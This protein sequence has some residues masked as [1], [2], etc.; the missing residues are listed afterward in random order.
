MSRSR[1]KFSESFK[2][3]AVDLVVSSGQ[4]VAKVARE[5]GINAGTLGNWVNA[6]KQDG[7]V[8]EKELSAGDAAELAQLRDTVRRQ[9][10][11]IEILKKAAAWFARES[12]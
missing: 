6:A 12:L 11:E 4:P 1:R 3:D 2:A 10:M 9:R 7:R 8:P 5:L